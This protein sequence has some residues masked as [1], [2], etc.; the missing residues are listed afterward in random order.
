MLPRSTV[1][2]AHAVATLATLALSCLLARGLATLLG[3]SRSPRQA[4]CG[5]A[6]GA[7]GAVG[8][9]FAIRHF[10]LAALLLQVDAAVV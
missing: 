5:T 8:L 6:L 1:Q 4:H 7:C 2:A 10:L 3:A 9:V